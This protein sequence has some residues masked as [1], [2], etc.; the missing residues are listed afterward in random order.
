MLDAD[1]DL[2]GLHLRIDVGRRASRDRSADDENVLAVERVRILKAGS[3]IPEE[4]LSVSGVI[5]Q[6]DECEFAQ[7]TAA[8]NPPREFHV[9][10]NVGR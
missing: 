5:A 1:L 6:I 9:S 3:I 10:T 7:V 4:Q 8:M 2:A